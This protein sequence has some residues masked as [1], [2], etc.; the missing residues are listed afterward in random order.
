MP[1]ST[2]LKDHGIQELRASVPKT[3]LMLQ[4]F[5]LM[6]ALNQ[7]IWFSG[8]VIFRPTRYQD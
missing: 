4:L 5:A 7:C 6:E 3:A 2:P 8:S 1:E